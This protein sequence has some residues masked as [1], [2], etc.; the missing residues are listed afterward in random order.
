MIESVKCSSRPFSIQNHSLV[1]ALTGSLLLLQQRQLVSD[2]PSVTSHKLPLE[3]L[4]TDDAQLAEAI[5]LVVENRSDIGNAFSIVQCAVALDVS[6]HYED[7]S[8]DVI[9]ENDKLMAQRNLVS[10]THTRLPG[11]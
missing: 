4:S 10:R 8:D 2:T 7:V 6:G 11:W 1:L 9:Q 5:V 3:F